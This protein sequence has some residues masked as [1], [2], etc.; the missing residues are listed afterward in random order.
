MPRWC[1]T[2]P[3]HM[4]VQILIFLRNTQATGAK[5]VCTKAI[6]VLN[7]ANLEISHNLFYFNSRLLRYFN[8]LVLRPLVISLDLVKKPFRS[9]AWC[10]PLCLISGQRLQRLWVGCQISV[11]HI[12][13]PVPGVR[14]TDVLAV[15]Q[16][17]PVMAS[18]QRPLPVMTVCGV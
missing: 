6:E 13:G 18:A 17:C 14:P 7:M 1:T 9:F 16:I 5:Q 8:L 15:C 2:F 3:L 4:T 10:S 12:R 11:V